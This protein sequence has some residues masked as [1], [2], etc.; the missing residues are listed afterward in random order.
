MK[1]KRNDKSWSVSDIKF[2]KYH[3]KREEQYKR[4]I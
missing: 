3:F 1:Q 4:F 2:K